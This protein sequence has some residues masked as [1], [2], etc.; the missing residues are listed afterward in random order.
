MTAGS[1]GEADGE[2]SFSL[3]L[4]L[5]SEQD[6]ND[7]AEGV[8]VEVFSS[9]EV[10]FFFGAISGG[11]LTHFRPAPLWGMASLL[12]VCSRCWWNLRDGTRPGRVRAWRHLPRGREGCFVKMVYLCTCRRSMK[13]LTLVGR[14]WLL[15]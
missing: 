11:V 7:E 10:R 5:S 9:G 6:D 14:F 4:Q 1:P 3:P 13:G 15:N 12:S 2:F 8:L